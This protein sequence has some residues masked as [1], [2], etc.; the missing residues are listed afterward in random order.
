LKKLQQKKL[1][2]KKPQPKKLQQKKLKGKL[3]PFFIAIAIC[4]LAKQSL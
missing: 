1:Q 2:Q 3:A 4:D